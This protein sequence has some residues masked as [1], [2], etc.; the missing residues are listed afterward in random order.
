MF[1]CYIASPFFNESQLN[2]VKLIE[3]SLDNAGI[4][5]FSPRSKGILIEMT[6]E[7]RKNKFKQIYQ[8]NIKQMDKS[9]IMIA[10]ID[11]RDLG[12]ATEIGWFGK[13]S[14]PIFSYSGNDYQINIMMREMVLCH[15]TNINNLITNIQEF[16]NNEELTIFDE[17]TKD[18]T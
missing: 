13:S 10:N 6:E 18:V 12:T 2:T 1:K 16:Q 14:K 5:Y 8:S 7:E 15:N 17:L 3:K 4:K 11:D 9:F